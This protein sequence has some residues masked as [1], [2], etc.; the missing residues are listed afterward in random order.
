MAYEPPVAVL[1]ACVL[2]PFHLRNLLIQCA[3]DRLIEARWSDAIHDEWINNLLAK[4]KTLQVAALKRT[5]DLMNEILPRANVA[6]YKKLIPNVDLNDPD[7]RHVAAVGIAAGASLIVTWNIR[8]FPAPEL[9]RHNMRP[10]TPDDLMIEIH[11][12]VP[13]L[14]IEAAANARRNLTKPGLTA[15]DFVEA[16]RRQNLRRFANAIAPRLTEL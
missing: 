12:R 13:L 5:R 4:S 8:D 2:Y 16:M 10:I 1:D 7:D 15:E 11:E 6:E 14:V 3:V 9:A